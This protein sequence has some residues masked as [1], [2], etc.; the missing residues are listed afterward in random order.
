[1]VVGKTLTDVVRDL[2][3]AGRLQTALKLSDAELLQQFAL[4]RDEAAF[5]ALL[6]R[7]G[8]LVFGVCRRLLADDHD[9]EDA[10]QATFL[11]LARRAASIGR[12]SL[13]GNWL[14]G[15]AHRVAARARKSGGRRRAREQ[16]GFDLAAVPGT[17]RSAEPDV[18]P[19]IHEELQ[20][21]PDKYR[22]PVVLC[23]L[24]GKTTEEAA[25]HLRWPVGTVKTRLHKARALLRGRLARRGVALTAGLLAANLLTAAAPAALLDATFQAALSFAAGGAVVGGASTPALALTKGVLQTMWLSK[26]KL[27]AAAALAVAVVA[28][29]GGL[30]YR[31]L[32]ADP[33]AKD[34]KKADKPKEDK[35]AIL[36][37][38]KVQAFEEGGKDSE[39]DEGK[40]FKAAT[41]TITAD[42]MVF[43]SGEEVHEVMYQL[44]PTS[45][46]KA[47][48]LDH[49]GKVLKGVY[50]L[51]G[52]TLKIC[53]SDPGG[54]RPTE[55]ASKEGSSSK[56]LVLKR[57][58]KDK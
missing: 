48:D 58:A 14:Y 38:W 4:Q 25:T 46:P 26:L 36:G 55:V 24:Q 23:Y 2:G 30:A 49:G 27:V 31:G 20:R 29:A 13:L 17:G 28:W 19:L 8:P 33:P 6:H 40:K 18:A 47:I 22:R 16:D 21:L 9:A 32:A 7:H 44:D 52:N 10:F 57:E 34:D 35:E 56:L 54:D 51:D 1:M 37:T 15:V 50:S 11:V 12:R 53:A 42:K 3:R 5:E 41:V 45:K 43:K 39:T